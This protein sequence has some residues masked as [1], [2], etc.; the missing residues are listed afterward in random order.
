LP[1]I[2]EFQTIAA[3]QPRHAIAPQPAGRDPPGYQPVPRAVAAI[4]NR[5]PAG[6]RIEPHMH[7]RDQLLYAVA[8]VM[9]VETDSE[10]WIVPPDRAVYLP[11]GTRHSVAIR[12]PLEMRS[13]YIDTGSTA[14]IE[15]RPAV[16]EVS[17][18][19]RALILALLEEPP[20]YREDGRGGL[21]A[22][23]ILIELTAARRLPLVVPMPADRRLR[24]LCDALLA[25]PENDATL[26]GWSAEAGASAR[27]LS[28][29]FQRQLNMGF[30]AWRQRV[31][32]HNAIE[33]L[34]AGQPIA[35]VARD[36]GYRSASAF[37]A[38]FRK[39]MGMAPSAIKQAA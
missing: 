16:I 26:E 18:L 36:N 8:G 29:L 35:R 6:Y 39:A 9:R 37:S 33:A 1:R 25:N 28:R 24:R 19:L 34:A 7:P 31:R 10:A 2:V 11:A 14:G 22:R 27:T 30:A 38:A 13:L 12:G 32:F 23:L 3:M 21:V 15:Q 17:D 20:L 4:P 5:Y